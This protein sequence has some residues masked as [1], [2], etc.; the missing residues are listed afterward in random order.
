MYASAATMTTQPCSIYSP[1][2]NDPDWYFNELLCL[3][4]PGA[5]AAGSGQRF[6][7]TCGRTKVP[8]CH[9]NH[10]ISNCTAFT[11]FNSNLS[12]PCGAQCL[13]AVE[14]DFKAGRPMA[15]QDLSKNELFVISDKH[16]HDARRA[17]DRFY[18]GWLSSPD[19][20]ILK[21]LSPQH[22]ITRPPRIAR[23]ASCR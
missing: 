16:S 13:V 22:A 18:A 1:D 3:K 11:F 17:L 10:T 8:F 6:K 2:R 19:L 9:P 4:I 14:Y 5:G 12:P 20:R 15:S 7:I 23:S 21:Y